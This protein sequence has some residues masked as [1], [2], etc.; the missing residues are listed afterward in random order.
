M[1]WFLVKRVLLVANV[2]GWVIALAVVR[3]DAYLVRTGPATATNPTNL[4][5]AETEQ[6]CPVGHVPY[7]PVPVSQPPRTENTE[8]H[9]SPWAEI[10]VPS[11]PAEGTCNHSRLVSRHH[12]LGTVVISSTVYA[13][14]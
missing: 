5:G 10:P 13:L 2:V 12:F 9:E 4:G 1:F 11:W 3:V 6:T 14:L 8:Q 7:H